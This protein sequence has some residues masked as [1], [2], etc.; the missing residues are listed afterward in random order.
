MPDDDSFW[1][2]N[3]E[4]DPFDDALARRLDPGG[5]SSRREWFL[6]L[7]ITRSEFASAHD[8][9]MAGRISRADYLAVKHRVMSEYAPGDACPPDP[10]DV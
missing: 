6:F 9:Y 4:P 8:A 7:L 3:D 1:G 2:G 5:S 10:F